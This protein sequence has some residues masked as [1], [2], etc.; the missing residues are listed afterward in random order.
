MNKPVQKHSYS[1][2]SKRNQNCC[3]VLIAVKF[4][5]ELNKVQNSLKSMYKNNLVQRNCTQFSCRKVIMNKSV[6]LCTLVYLCPPNIVKNLLFY[7]FAYFKIYTR[8]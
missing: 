3:N 8:I 1:R 5:S 4:S 7:C 6:S 2:M